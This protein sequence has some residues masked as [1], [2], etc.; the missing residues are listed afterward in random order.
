MVA[1][2]VTALV[3]ACGGGGGDTPAT[4]QNY[5]GPGSVWTFEKTGTSF[6]AVKAA[7]FVSAPTL[8]VSGTTVP[9]ASGFDLLTVSS[10][11]GTDAPAVGSKGWALEVPGLAMFVNPLEAGSDQAVVM[12]SAG[13]CPETDLVA[14]WIA[15]K[16]E[17][18]VDATNTG[19][20]FF[21]T[22][23]FDSTTFSG[24]VVNRYALDSTFTDNGTAS[25]GPGTCTDGIV[26][27][28]A[29]ADDA[30]MY[31]TSSGGAIVHTEVS[32]TA[33]NNFL[34][35]LAQKAITDISDFDGSYAGL[36]FDDSQTSGEKV[37]PLGM[38]CTSG[39]CMVQ[40]I[41]DVETG[42]PLAGNVVVTLDGTLNELGSGLITGTVDDGDGTPG[43]MA[44]MTDNNA[45][46]TGK[47]IIN[48]VGQS[49]GDN[50]KMFNALFVSK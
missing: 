18:G 27:L 44:C 5:T 37:L 43:N 42:T 33:N 17:T 24:N 26:D 20:D 11:T 12:I 15:V 49:P 13:T 50:T 6:T 2:M 23:T 10:A 25:V 47:K 14:N 16:K 1:L 48:C 46:G 40:I 35:A 31:L 21:G 9:L 7:D 19:S 4:P 41:L 28:T 30:V 22:A 45:A 32:D 34:F 36:L 29:T 39:T 8:T 3:I 38:T